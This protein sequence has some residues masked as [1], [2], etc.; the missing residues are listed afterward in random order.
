MFVC[1][2]EGKIE[3]VDIKW[4]IAADRMYKKKLKDG[5]LDNFTAEQID[6]MKA[7]CERRTKELKEL[8]D[9]GLVLAKA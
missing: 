5:E 7:L 2:I 1:E 4:G 3:A 6:A 8:Y 9:L